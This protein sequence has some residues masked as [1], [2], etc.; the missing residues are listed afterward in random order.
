[1]PLPPSLILTLNGIA[2]VSI[3]E[4]RRR[5]IAIASVTIFLPALAAPRTIHEIDFKNALY[6]WDQPS[7]A[8]PS[9]WQWLAEAPHGG[10]QLKNGQHK[11]SDGSEPG[12]KVPYL[13]LGSVTYGDFDGDGHEEAAV[14]LLYSTGGTANWHYLYV[15][16][17]DGTRPKLLTVLQSGS[18][19]DG[20][21]V[22]VAIQKQ[23][24]TLD[25]ADS[26]LRVADCCSKGFV[27]VRYQWARDRFV[28]S[29]VRRRGKLGR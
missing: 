18:R 9:K 8:V 28:E 15:Y 13:L 23:L 26:A 11:F 27:R 3:F 20:G 22:R 16:T 19:A 2:G 25:F 14:D 5:R 29:G 21:L 24:L 17:L 6:A 10:I 4:A 12:E 1:M 7:S